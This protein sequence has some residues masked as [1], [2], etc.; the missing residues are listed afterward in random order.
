M[1]PKGDRRRHCTAA[2]LSATSSRRRASQ[3]STMRPLWETTGPSDVPHREPMHSRVDRCADPRP[4]LRS[5]R[6]QPDPRV[7]LP[8]VLSIG[9]RMFPR[10]GTSPGNQSPDRSGRSADRPVTHRCGRQPDLASPGSGVRIPSSVGA[11]CKDVVPRPATA[12]PP[13]PLACRLLRP[14]RPADHTSHTAM[15]GG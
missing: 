12:E 6:P 10:G 14:E 1:R 11:R 13:G 3:A 15:T 8:L 4:H 9:L 5:P 7:C 2:I